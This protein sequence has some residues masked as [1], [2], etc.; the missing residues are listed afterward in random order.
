MLGRQCQSHRFITTVDLHRQVEGGH[1]ELGVRGLV[2]LLDHTLEQG[3]HVVGEHRCSKPQ[4]GR[5]GMAQTLDLAVQHRLKALEHAFD[6]PALAVQA[7]NGGRLDVL[8]QV[9]PQSDVRVPRLC[10]R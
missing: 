7:R 2:C 8:G 9:A 4:Q 6:T 10:G 5:A 1:I 3:Q